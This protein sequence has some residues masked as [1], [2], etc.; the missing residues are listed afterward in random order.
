VFHGI[1]NGQT[2]VALKKLKGGGDIGKFQ[3]ECSILFN[4]HHPNIVQFFGLAVLQ[5]EYY[6]VMEFMP[7]GSLLD[8]LKTEGHLLTL[9]HQISL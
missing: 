7:R 4:L 1:W 2:Q 9:K 8:V 6:L 3:D 5:S